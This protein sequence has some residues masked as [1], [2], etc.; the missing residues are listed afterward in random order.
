MF[1][2]PTT[3]KHRG[4]IN[5][6]RRQLLN[7]GTPHTKHRRALINKGKTLIKLRRRHTKHRRTPKTEKISDKNRIVYMKHNEDTLDTYMTFNFLAV[8]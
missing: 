4:A 2:L 7:P 6:S 8:F 3:T 1:L 5:T